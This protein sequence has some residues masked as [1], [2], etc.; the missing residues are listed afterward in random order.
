METTTVYKVVRLMDSQ[1]F[2]YAAGLWDIVY[3]PNVWQAGLEGTPVFAFRALKFARAL[4]TEAREWCRPEVW[5]ADAQNVR[6]APP[7]VGLSQEWARFWRGD[8]A[9]ER[10]D[11][12]DGSVIADK[13]RITKR[14]WP[15]G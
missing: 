6:P 8:S 15:E 2:S 4:A 10:V 5:R 14:V 7:I 1:R 12:P 9:A 13:L 3:E 11:P